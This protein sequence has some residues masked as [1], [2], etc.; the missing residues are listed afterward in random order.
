[1][2]ASPTSPERSGSRGVAAVVVA[3]F[4]LALAA[5]AIDLLVR[6]DAVRSPL[7]ENRRPAPP[8]DRIVDVA[9]ASRYPGQFE[10]WFADRL[11]LR[12]RLLA[13]D[14]WLRYLVFGTEPAPMIVPGRDGWLFFGADDS[15]PVHRGVLPM[16]RAE[17]ETWKTVLEAERDWCRAAGAEFVFAIAPNKQTVYPERWPR[18][19]APVGPTRLDQFVEFL[20]RESDVCFVD[21]RP[22]LAAEREQD[23]PAEGD[24]VYHPLGSH[25]TYRGG[26]A[27]WNAIAAALPERFASQLVRPRGLFRRREYSDGL[28]DS[29]ARQTYVAG[30]VRQR[31]YDLDPIDDEGVVLRAR[32]SEQIDGSTRD[33]PDLPSVLVVHDSF[34][35]W[36]LR[37]IAP[38]CRRLDAIWAHAFPKEAVTE[39]RPEVVVQ[40]YTE[41]MLVWGI[42]PLA[43]DLERVSRAAFDALEPCGGPLDLVAEGVVRAEGRLVLARGPEGLACDS[44]DE[45][46]VLLLPG[47]DVPPGRELAVRIDVT[48]PAHTRFLAFFQVRTEP[49]FSRRRSVSATLEAGRNDLCFRV[50]V[51]DVTGP[52][53]VRLGTERGRYVVHAIELRSAP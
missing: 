35:P 36:F 22:A 9:S 40:V 48:A 43:H 10:A 8:P 27:A 25:W 6:N 23:L 15:V 42:P 30:L 18:R 26:V 28:A 13:G 17:L 31:Y 1:M 19:L 32:T 39:L 29:L 12:D 7:R 37:Q 38:A 33:A 3:G 46:G 44:L 4:L 20:R 34:G 50:K 53:K 49:S 51:P 45:S 14:Q 21:L 5:P 52:L 2:S 11:G 16:T 47:C 41:R 24:Y